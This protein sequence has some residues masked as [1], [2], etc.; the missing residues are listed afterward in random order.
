MASRSESSLSDS[1]P[2]GYVDDDGTAYL[3]YT[4]DGG[5]H[6]A[7]GRAFSCS[8][9]PVDGE[10]KCTI[11][12]KITCGAGSGVDAACMRECLV[13]AS[14]LSHPNLTNHL[15]YDRAVS[16]RGIDYMIRMEHAGESLFAVLDRSERGDPAL[17]RAV[18][19]D[20]ACALSFLHTRGCM[21]P[22]PQLI[23]L[24]ADFAVRAERSGLVHG[25]IGP[26]NIGV[27]HVG[28]QWLA[29]IYDFATME[30][31]DGM[32][33]MPCMTTETCRPP[34][35]LVGDGT[36]TSAYDMWSYGAVVMLT[37][38]H[39]PLFFPP[40]PEH[41]TAIDQ[42]IIESTAVSSRRADGAVD[43]FT[44]RAQLVLAYISLRLPL[45]F[46][47][48]P[49]A[50]ERH[51]IGTTA[52]CDPRYEHPPQHVSALLRDT[53][54]VYMGDNSEHPA[55]TAALEIIDACLQVRVDARRS[56]RGVIETLKHAGLM[57]SDSD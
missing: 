48:E 19:C 33:A 2:V 45:V 20:V 49:V 26:G 22:T 55:V 57:W 21:R 37:V 7:F 6:G 39:T 9:Q 47:G 12:K 3:M 15:A 24:D 11:T 44:H 54:A 38:A 52:V 27:Q 34:E 30:P 4:R 53:V 40:P 51:Q 14:L 56:A 13:G 29:K 8:E 1:S 31:A 10:A 23:A 41:C 46:R 17:L 36:V 5:G 16:S 35:G 28:G 43:E 50:L 18:M 42:Y 32:A 25:D